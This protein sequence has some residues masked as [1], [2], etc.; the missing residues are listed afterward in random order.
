MGDDKCMDN[1]SNY[2]IRREFTDKVHREMATKVYDY[3]NWHLDDS[4]GSEHAKEADIKDGIDYFVNVNGFHRT[5]QER[6]R[7]DRAAKGYNDIT[8]RYQYPGNTTHVN[9]EWFKITA[10]YFLYG[11][12]PVTETD[13]VTSDTKFTK[14]VVIDLRLFTRL[15][16]DRK[17]VIGSER[18]SSIRDGVLYGGL[19]FNKY[20]SGDNQSTFIAFDVKHLFN[21]DSNLIVIESGYG[22]PKDVRLKH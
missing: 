17:I 2:S 18:I 10:D 11:V 5:V 3:L 20:R 16:D 15:V 13:S 6:F 14:L 8:L 12:V 9:S 19:N 22:T 1:F 21:L 7:R 4:R